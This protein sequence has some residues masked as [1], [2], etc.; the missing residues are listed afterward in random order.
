LGKRSKE[1]G[2]RFEVGGILV[3]AV[4]GALRLRLEVSSVQKTGESEIRIYEPLFFDLICAYSPVLRWSRPSSFS[5]RI[6]NVFPQPARWQEYDEKD[7]FLSQFGIIL[8]MI[9]SSLI[10]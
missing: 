9:I 8:P 5:F 4:R 1:K 2:A 3:I 6:G 10:I 7:C